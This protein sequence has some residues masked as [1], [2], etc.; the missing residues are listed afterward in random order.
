MSTDALAGGWA[1]AL[2]GDRKQFDMFFDRMLDGF[3]YNKIIVDKKG[4]SV[5]YGF[6]EINHAF[7]KMTGLKSANYR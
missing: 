4:K 5:D 6:L 1:K 2:G 3:A 7:E